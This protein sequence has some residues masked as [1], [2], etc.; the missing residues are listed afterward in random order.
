MTDAFAMDRRALIGRIALLIGAT[1][2][3]VDLFAAPAQDVA[4]FLP[5]ASYK[6]LVAVADTLIPVTDTPG[7]VAAKVPEN[8]DALLKNWA[9][10]E[11]RASLAGA[12][13]TIDRSAMGSEGKAFADLTPERRKTVLVAHDL[14]ALKPVPPT[15]KLVGMAAL[16][17]PPS[18]AD[19]GY[20]MLKDIVLS[21]YYWSEIGMTEELV[22]EHVPGEWVPSLKVTPETR[23]FAAP[24]KF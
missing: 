3:P 21:L 19:P 24:G 6:L 1:A 20:A 8:F 5:M 16:M 13:A 12:L 14:A 2:L 4:R 15:D 18:V 22:Y 10:E 7:A 11:S 9:S 17:A 23:P